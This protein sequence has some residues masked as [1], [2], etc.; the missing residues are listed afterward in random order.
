MIPG[1]PSSLTTPRLLLRPYQPSDAAWYY[2]MALANQEHLR[3]Y[4][5]GNSIMT[6]HTPAE[7]E[8]VVQRMAD[9]WD[10]R[11]CFFFAAFEKQTGGFTC[12]IYVGPLSWD[13]PEF[14]IGYIV[15]KDHQG[16]GYVTEAARVARDFIFEHLHAQRAS[17]ETDDTNLRSI[18]V[19]ERL[20]MVKEAH[21]R[22]NRRNPAHKTTPNF[23]EEIVRTRK[24]QH[25]SFL[26]LRG[27]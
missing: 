24:R 21:F 16:Q 20:G 23:Q 11:H 9:D 12:Q 6:I 8:V 26:F 2:E 3:R 10:A 15:E 4:E 13:L 22:Q 27:R 14:T 7:A 25:E 17:I 19:A 5:A 18:R 1:L